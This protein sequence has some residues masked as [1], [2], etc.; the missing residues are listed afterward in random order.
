MDQIYEEKVW[1]HMC[2]PCVHPSASF[3]KPDPE[4]ENKIT[5]WSSRLSNYLGADACL[6]K[7]K[8]SGESRCKA[9]LRWHAFSS[10]MFSGSISSAWSSWLSWSLYPRLTLQSIL[11]TDSPAVEACCKNDVLLMRELLSS[12]NVRA[13]DI[14][15]ENRTLL[16]VSVQA[17]SVMN[18]FLC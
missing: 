15:E 2:S 5:R 10:T 8:V 9:L 4:F 3:R 12:G 14:T 17:H 16:L 1:A 13:N 18:T 11:P 6:I 7:S